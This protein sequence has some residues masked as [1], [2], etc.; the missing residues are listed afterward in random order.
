MVERVVVQLIDDL[1]GGD[2]DETVHF[3]LDGED[4]RVDLS[5]AN[6]SALREALAPYI[7]A[8]RRVGRASQQG[9]GRSR[10][11]SGT[12]AGEAAAI[13]AWAIERGYQVGSRGQVPAD[14][15]AAYRAR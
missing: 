12:A 11:A 9:T 6:A 2:A 15:R 3:G 14:V 7:G 10:R 1:D 8:G 4:Y 5:E 13:R